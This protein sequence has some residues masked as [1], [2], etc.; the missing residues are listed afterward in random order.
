MPGPGDS[1]TGL[2]QHPSI[3]LLRPPAPFASSTVFAERAWFCGLAEAGLRAVAGRTCAGEFAPLD[4]RASRPRAGL[5]GAAIEA[6]RTALVWQT[7]PSGEGA[8]SQ[9]RK[10]RSL[11]SGTSSKSE[12]EPPDSAVTERRCIPPGALWPRPGLS[13]TVSHSPT[14]PLGCADATPRKRLTSASSACPRC[15]GRG[16]FGSPPPARG[17]Q[18]AGVRPRQTA[19]VGAAAGR[20]GAHLPPRGAARR[21]ASRAGTVA[22]AAASAAAVFSS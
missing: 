7:A 22:P 10:S 12:F 8:H 18:L 6:L 5:D 11:Y 16:T 17:V 1:R 14:L 13:K 3:K 19:G 15:A 20:G 4:A 9:G 2:L 21:E